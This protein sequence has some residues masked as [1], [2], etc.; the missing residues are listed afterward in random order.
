[1]VMKKISFLFVFMSITSSYLQATSPAWLGNLQAEFKRKVLCY[2]GHDPEMVELKK[3]IYNQNCLPPAASDP[4]QEEKFSTVSGCKALLER[5]EVAPS[6]WPL[7]NEEIRCRRLE[8]ERFRLEQPYVEL[9]L[10]KAKNN[11]ESV[12]QME[13]L[14]LDIGLFKERNAKGIM[15]ILHVYGGS[16]NFTSV[17]Y[18]LGTYCREIKK[19]KTKY[20][21]LVDLMKDWIE[22]HYTQE[23][24]KAAIHVTDGIGMLE[25]YQTLQEQWPEF[26]GPPNESIHKRI[27]VFK[28]MSKRKELCAIFSDF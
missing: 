20:Q 11:P 25:A 28:K 17:F 26:C 18:R 16:L 27:Q 7:S 6:Q 4:L 22:Q 2:R 5:L 1:M 13:A 21:P 12:F 3:Y 24:F 19:G 14:Q 10:E 15:A 9:L 23:T 8:E